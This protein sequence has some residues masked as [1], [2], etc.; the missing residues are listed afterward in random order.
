M[1]VCVL[2]INCF[3]K[4]K[5]TKDIIFFSFVFDLCCSNNLNAPNRLKKGIIKNLSDY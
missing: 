4:I 1:Y 5:E 3:T 2:I